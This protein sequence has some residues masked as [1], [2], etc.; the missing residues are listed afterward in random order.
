MQNL[1]KK[2]KANTAGQAPNLRATDPQV[3]ELWVRAGGRCEFHGCNDFLFQD[4]LTTNNAKLA[5]I[6]HIIARSKNGPRGN[7]PLP[8]SQRN[9]IENLF[10][11]CTKHHRLIDNRK[12]VSKYPKDLLLRYKQ[13]HE[14]RIRYVTGL[15]DENET[16]VVRLIGNV[17]GNTVSISNE[18]IREAVLKSSDRYPRYL[19]AE[20]TI[21][22]DLRNLNDR[23]TTQY[24]IQ[25]VERIK[26]VIDRRLVPAIQNGETRHLSAFALARIPFLAYLGH[27]IGDKVP[28]EIFQK[29]RNGNEGWVWHPSQTEPRFVF[30]KERDGS[31]KSCVAILISLSGQ[32][33]LDQLPETI[34]DNFTI[35]SHTPDGSAPSRALLASKNSLE[36]FRATYANLLREI[37]KNYPAAKAIHIFPAVSI[38]AGIILGRELLKDVSPS[39][40]IYDKS[41]TKFEKAITINSGRK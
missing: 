36:Q 11:A 8:L 9:R 4:R 12:L 41:G 26:D 14:E 18:E 38:S 35:Y 39:L 32:V 20:N 17:R 5:D 3:I 33:L 22:I 16:T 7:D 24:W 19:G 23:D 25:G 28:L 21:E 37:E 2:K 30:Q 31:D 40:I 10:L 13:A 6:A 29:Q 34:S 1:N 27:A 15:G